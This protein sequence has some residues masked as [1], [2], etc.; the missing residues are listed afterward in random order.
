MGDK[1]YALTQAGFNVVGLDYDQKT[2]DKVKQHMPEL[3]FTHGDVREL[4]FENSHFD[5]YWSFGVI[6]HFYEGYEKISSEMA[7]VIKKD[8]FLFLTVPSVSKIRA[9]KARLNKYPLF[10]ATPKNIQEFYQFA[11]P[12]KE[13]ISHFSNKGF[14]L[15]ELKHLDGIKGLKDEIKLS[16]AFVT[17]LYNGKNLP[18]KIIKKIVDV[19][20]KKWFNHISLFVFK[21]V[22]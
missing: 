21:K 8:G 3:Y 18:I 11:L 20:S 4:P 15:K 9:L 6:E 22:N 10:E 12:E 13:V 14:Q 19:T 17:Y 7:R 5:G 1:V 16:R 2:L